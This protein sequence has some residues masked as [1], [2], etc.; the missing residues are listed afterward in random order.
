[1]IRVYT[2]TRHVDS[3]HKFLHLINLEHEIF[4]TKNP[5]SPEH[6]L[7][8]FDLGVS[9]SYPRKITKNLLSIPSKGFVN[10]HAAPLPEYKG[11]LV[12]EEAIENKETH[13]GV[14]LHVV[15]EHYDTGPI[16]K[17]VNI[18]LHEPSVTKQQLGAIGHWFMFH[19]FK[20]TIAD[21]YDGNYSQEPQITSAEEIF[22]K[23]L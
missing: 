15:D 23:N 9:Y 7:E 11:W 5:P 17:R 18:E 13:W 6:E 4:T 22:T 14:T 21:V 10:Y 1:L 2:K 19:L 3:I 20:Q 8:P 12:Y 16:I